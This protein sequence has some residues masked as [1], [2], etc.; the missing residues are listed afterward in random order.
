VV[1]VDDQ[2]KGEC[3]WFMWMIRIK[4]SVGGVVIDMVVWY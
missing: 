2:N 3:R 1:H 4:E